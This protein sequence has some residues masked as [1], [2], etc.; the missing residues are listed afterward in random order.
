MYRVRRAVGSPT[1]FFS[2]SYLVALDYT[3]YFKVEVWHPSF[4]EKKVIRDIS[5]DNWVI[6]IW[7][8]RVKTRKRFGP[9]SLWNSSI[10]WWRQQKS[11]VN[12]PTNCSITLVS[13]QIARHFFFSLKAGCLCFHLNEIHNLFKHG[14]KMA[15][16]QIQVVFSLP[17]LA[18]KWLYPAIFI[19][20]LAFQ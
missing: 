12:D 9:F 5:K 17:V 6:G 16:L 20:F 4:K 15:S 3:L 11:R 13:G 7:R 19:N 10:V 2:Y 14:G 18:F 8:L 1:F